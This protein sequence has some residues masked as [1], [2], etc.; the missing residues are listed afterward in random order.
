MYYLNVV[1][2]VLYQIIA[3]KLKIV[4]DSLNVCTISRLEMN[5]KNPGRDT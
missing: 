1:T 4:I 3:Q 2:D 5:K